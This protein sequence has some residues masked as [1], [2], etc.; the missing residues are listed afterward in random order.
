MSNRALLNS[1]GKLNVTLKRSLI[2]IAVGLF[3]L[4]NITGCVSNDLSLELPKDFIREFIA[5]HETM[6]D[7]SLVYYYVKS[8]Q[9]EV[10]ERIDV[11]CRINKAKG[12]YE[13]LGNATFDFSELDIQLIDKKEV[14]LDDE[15]VMFAKVTVKG[16]YKMQIE[17]ETQKIEANEVIVLQMARNEWKVSKSN[18]PWS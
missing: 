16:S 8:D 7:E 5:K 17:K 3:A 11:S 6:V 10:A 9:P 18:N 4:V 12:M 15:P 14:Y 2:L 1:V 13:I